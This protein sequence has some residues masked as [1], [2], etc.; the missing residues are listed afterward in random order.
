MGRD[1]LPTHGA[2]LG[3][4]RRRLPRRHLRQRTTRPPTGSPPTFRGLHAGDLVN[5]DVSAELD[6]YWAD[7]GASARRSASPCHRATS[8]QPD[9]ARRLVAARHGGAPPGP[10]IRRRGHLCGH[11]RPQPEHTC[12][13]RGPDERT[14]PAAGLPGTS[15]TCAGTASAGSLHEAPACPASRTH[16]DPT[17]LWEGLVLA[18]EPFL[19]TGATAAVRGRSTAGRTGTLLRT[20]RPTACRPSSSTYDIVVTQGKPLVD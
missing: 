3:P 15:P 8:S 12:P 4:A 20:T 17:V 13:A 9:A 16:G 14:G 5:V 10:A 18:V 6:G 1:V 2:E 11:G 7:T 19:S